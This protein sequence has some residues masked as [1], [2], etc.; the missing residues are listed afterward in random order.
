MHY[1]IYT[2]K[3]FVHAFRILVCWLTMLSL[4]TYTFWVLTHLILHLLK[5]DFP[6]TN[7]K[8]TFIVSLGYGIRLVNI[9]KKKNQNQKP[10][11]SLRRTC[12]MYLR[13]FLFL[14]FLYLFIFFLQDNIVLKAQASGLLEIKPQLNQLYGLWQITSTL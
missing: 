12:F 6:K 3:Q 4:M 14:S 10:C 5:C 1:H 7:K 11:C 2:K 13:V 9:T 8:K